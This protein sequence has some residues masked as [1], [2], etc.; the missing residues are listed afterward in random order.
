MRSGTN[1]KISECQPRP[2][3]LP[4]CFGRVTNQFSSYRR[5]GL[6]MTNNK[7]QNVASQSS[8]QNCHACRLPADQLTDNCLINWY[9]RHQL[10]STGLFLEER[11]LKKTVQSEWAEQG[12]TAYHKR[13]AAWEQEKKMT[14]TYGKKKRNKNSSRQKIQ[15]PSQGDKQKQQQHKTI[16]TCRYGW[17]KKSR[18]HVSD[19]STKKVIISNC[20]Q[21]K[22]NQ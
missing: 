8:P 9:K 15:G 3:W 19:S 4:L 2:D 5:K 13:H 14:V 21:T 7:G 10:I 11:M 1:S 17:D 20:W 22:R 16:S 18:C 12:T 6:V